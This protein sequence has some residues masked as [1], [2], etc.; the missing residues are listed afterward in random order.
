MM[1]HRH[2][3]M[4]CAILLAVAMTALPRFSAAAM[5]DL[6]GVWTTSDG[7]STRPAAEPL[8]VLPLHPDA[9]RRYEACRNE[10]LEGLAKTAGVQLP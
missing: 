3:A 9:K 5:P 6:T 2:L 7:A 8:P 10:R 1:Q 4:A